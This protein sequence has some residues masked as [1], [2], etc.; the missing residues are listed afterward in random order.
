MLTNKQKRTIRELIH[1]NSGWQIEDS[2][3]IN[4]AFDTELEGDA[5]EDARN[6]AILYGLKV[7]SRVLNEGDSPDARS[8]ESPDTEHPTRP[9]TDSGR[10]E[11]HED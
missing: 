5:W 2:E 8:T 6:E 1:Y 11:S 4:P 7:N 9:D 10:V 3:L